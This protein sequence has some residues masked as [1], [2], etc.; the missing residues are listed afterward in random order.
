MA[1][2]RKRYVIPRSRS[3][4]GNPFPQESAVFCKTWQKQNILE[5][6]LPQVTF[7][8]LRND[9]RV[10]QWDKGKNCQLSIVNCQF[11]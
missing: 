8:H 5:N 10:F 7:G 6:G 1:A 2:C 4:R 9:I 3:G 11:F